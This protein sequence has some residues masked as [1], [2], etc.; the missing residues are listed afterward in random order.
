MFSRV[1]TQRSLVNLIGGIGGI[2]IAVG[3]FIIGGFLFETGSTLFKIASL[4]GNFSQVSASLNVSA[5]AGACIVQGLSAVLI[6][7]AIL[8]FS[9]KFLLGQ[10][11][12]NIKYLAAK[13][14]AAFLL[15]MISGILYCS[16][17]LTSILQYVLSNP[18]VLEYVSSSMSAAG[19]T[20]LISWIHGFKFG[21]M[22]AASGFV[23]TVACVLAELQNFHASLTLV[24]VGGCLMALA[25]PFLG[26]ALIVGGIAGLLRISTSDE[27]LKKVSTILL[28]AAVILGSIHFI[29]IGTKMAALSAVMSLITKLVSNT[30]G[31]IKGVNALFYASAVLTIVGGIFT[32]MS[33]AFLVAPRTYRFP[34]RE[35][36]LGVSYRPPSAP[37][38]PGAYVQYSPQQQIQQ[39]PPYGSSM[40]STPQMAPPQSPAPSQPAPSAQAQTGASISRICPQCGA[41]VPVD[42]PYCPRCGY[43][44]S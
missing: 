24:V 30:P 36:G 38:Y 4:M 16:S 44:F 18:S 15:L 32:L 10:E 33:S 22:L 17:P 41:I 19:G 31:V 37:S 40:P 21:V 39:A 13:V 7:I 25:F 14:G 42:Y 11:P 3:L 9:F 35:P 29:G 23:L 2:M 27:K 43:R 6:A 12:P 34:Y 8:V 26:A 20:A 1:G 28:A 5:A